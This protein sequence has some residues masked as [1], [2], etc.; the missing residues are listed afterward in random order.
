MNL[1]PALEAIEPS[2]FEPGARLYPCSAR[3]TDGTVSECVYFITADTARRLFGPAGIEAVSGRHRIAVE[4]VSNVFV[5][6]ARLPAKFA[7]QIYQAGETHYGC[8]TF[9]LVFSR[10]RREEYSVG[11]FIDFLPFPPGRGPSDVKEVFHHTRS[12]RASRVPE[13]RWCVYSA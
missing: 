1:L 12:I 10:W 9:T 2:E 4:E 11:G 13:Y 8:F 5:S 7:N 6:P 3:L